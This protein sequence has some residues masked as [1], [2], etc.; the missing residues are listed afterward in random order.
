MELFSLSHP[1]NKNFSRP[2]GSPTSL[3]AARLAGPPGGTKAGDTVVAAV[4]LAQI[5]KV[6]MPITKAVAAVLFDGMTAM[7]AVSDLM[8]R[9]ARSENPDAVENP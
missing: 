6:E 3:A 2:R 9:D 1:A 4:E 5:W 8:L 7:E